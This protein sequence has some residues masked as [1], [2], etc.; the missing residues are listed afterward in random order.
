MAAKKRIY[1]KVV[2]VDVYKSITEIKDCNVLYIPKE[3]TKNMTDILNSV[4]NHSILLVT[5]ETGM[6]RNGSCL[7]LLVTEEGRVVFE[8]NKAAFER[9]DLVA[10][11]Q[12]TQ[13]AT[14]FK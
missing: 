5:D 14:V 2:R 10:S 7:N 3:Q 8:M 13:S 6:A 4:G 12:L 11:A 9:A 1:G